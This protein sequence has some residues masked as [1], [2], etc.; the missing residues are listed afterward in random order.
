MDIKS[1][2][3]DYEN[4]PSF[5]ELGNDIEVDVLVIGGGISGILAARKLK[6]KGI[7]VVLLE[8]NKIGNII[9]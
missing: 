6:E 5:E 1:I 3:K 2:W 7:N 9:L 8:K 4:I